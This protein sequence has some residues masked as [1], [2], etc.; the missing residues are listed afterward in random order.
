MRKI[1]FFGILLLMAVFV[2]GCSQKSETNTNTGA[3]PNYT[4][5]QTTT[6]TTATTGSGAV[7]LTASNLTVGGGTYTNTQQHSYCCRVASPGDPLCKTE[8]D[9][10]TVNIRILSLD[11]KITDVKCLFYEDGSPIYNLGT[12][13]VFKTARGGLSLLKFDLKLEYNTSHNLRACCDSDTAV[14]Q[15]NQLC[16]DFV[17]PTSIYC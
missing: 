14:M 7:S 10:Y 6:G 8:T 9:T 5:G 1:I 11:P 12:D 17:V 16:M 15:T 3:Q 2:L 4:G 13:P